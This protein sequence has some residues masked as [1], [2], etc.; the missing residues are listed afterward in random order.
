MHRAE[1]ILAAIKTQLTGLATT[2]ANVFRGRSVRLQ[3]NQHPAL[4]IKMGAD[5]RLAEYSQA[6]MDRALE[7]KIEIR[8]KSSTDQLDT[9]LNKIREEVTK[10]LQAA[11]SLS[12]AYVIKLDELDADEPDESGEGNQPIGAQRMEWVVHYRRS[13]TDPGA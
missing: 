11:P 6:L 7:V 12:L 1:S 10:A 4:I 8:T 5:K 2:G 9:E 3:D 13:Y